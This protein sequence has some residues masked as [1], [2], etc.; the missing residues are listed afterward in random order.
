MVAST[1]GRREVGNSRFLGVPVIA[2]PRWPIP[3]KTW[4]FLA[5]ILFAS[6]AWAQQPSQQL[7][8][9]WT[10]TAGSQV[11]R[12]T[13]TAETSSRIPNGAQGT[14]TLLAGDGELVAEGTWSA[15]KS[16]RAWQGTW[17]ARAGNGRPLSGS[18][19]ASISD[20]NV[21]TFAG[22][23]KAA[24]KKWIEGAWQTGGSGGNWW[25]QG[26]QPSHNH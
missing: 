14:W 17:S 20:P 21:K 18:W 3:M 16:A 15:R 26:S 7:R 1:L 8:G 10:A 25:L 4:I 9:R 13:W 23:L 2:A 19:S 24:T 5:A 12:G 22:M 6:C 11:F